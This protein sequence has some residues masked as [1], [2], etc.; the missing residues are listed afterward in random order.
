LN[1][2]APPK[3]NP[4]RGSRAK[5]PI[6]LYLFLAVVLASIVGA[7]SG[8]FTKQLSCADLSKRTREW[9]EPKLAVWS[10]MGTR[11]GYENF[12]AQDRPDG[13]IS[14]LIS[15][16]F[17]FFKVKESEIRLSRRFSLTEE[18]EKWTMLKWGPP[19]ETPDCM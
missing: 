6:A 7:V 9:K 2:P 3:D 15:G 12:A 16:N 8:T 17:K 4:V 18:P 11:D 13:V 5:H 1:A 19:G 10:Y 14:T